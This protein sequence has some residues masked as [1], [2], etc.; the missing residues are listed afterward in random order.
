MVRAL[1]DSSGCALETIV[2]AG[3]GGLVA[4]NPVP[5]STT[6]SRPGRSKI[7][8]RLFVGVRRRDVRAV[9]REE[10]Q[11]EFRHVRD[12]RIAG[13]TGIGHHH[14]YRPQRSVI[15]NLHIDLR[16]TLT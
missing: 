2:P 6:T 14:L 9:E 4:P 15:G 12:G 3:V 1:S 8:Q 16:G 11:R 13:P 5:Y 10:R 7:R